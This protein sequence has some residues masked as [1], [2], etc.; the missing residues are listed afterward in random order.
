MGAM[1]LCWP[2]F[3]KFSAI[4]GIGFAVEASVITL[5][6]SWWALPPTVARCFS[7]PS[8]V[9]LTWW[10]NRKYNFRSQGSLVAEGRRYFLAQATG[11]LSNL[12][13]FALCVSLVPLFSVWPVAGLAVGAVAGLAVNFFLS[14]VFVFKK[15]K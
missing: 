10:L 4:G 3:L 14:S 1:P 12:G 6:G 5:T 13:V 8:A 7:F 15:G 11:A 2:R 9:M